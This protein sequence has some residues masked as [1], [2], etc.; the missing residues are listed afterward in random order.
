MQRLSSEAM[1]VQE[2]PTT[3]ELIPS[4]DD[5][6]ADYYM[7]DEPEDEDDINDDMNQQHGQMNRRDC[8]DDDDD[9]L[10]RRSSSILAATTSTTPLTHL[11]LKRVLNKNG[12]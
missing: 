6:P 4:H 11:N 3:W 5:N 12:I 9:E 7:N 1:M 8:I 2:Y 10:G